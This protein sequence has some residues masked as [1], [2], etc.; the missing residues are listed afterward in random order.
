MVFTFLVVRAP[1]G[2]IQGSLLTMGIVMVLCGLFIYRYPVPLTILA[3]VLQVLVTAVVAFLNPALEQA[4]WVGLIA[5]LI[6]LGRAVHVAITYE[7]ANAVARSMLASAPVS[8]GV[9]RA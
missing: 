2:L 4:P 6:G 5:L 7:R 9:P 3:L 1:T 8:R